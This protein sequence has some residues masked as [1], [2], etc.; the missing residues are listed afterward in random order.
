MHALSR[1]GA[2][3]RR[4]GYLGCDLSRLPGL[5]PGLGFLLVSL[6]INDT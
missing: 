6:I 4:E 5:D 3:A 1:E 2:E